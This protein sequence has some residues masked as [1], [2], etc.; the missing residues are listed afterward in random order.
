MEAID[1]VKPGLGAIQIHRVD[2]LDSTS[3]ATEGEKEIYLLKSMIKKKTK[4]IFFSN[5]KDFCQI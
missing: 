1:E 4:I 3:E 5:T 2:E